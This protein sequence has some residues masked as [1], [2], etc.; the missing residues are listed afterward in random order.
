[1]EV[2]LGGATLPCA[3]PHH[4]QRQLGWLDGMHTC[5]PMLFPL[6]KLICCSP[7]PSSAAALPTLILFKNGRP[8]DRVEGVLM[9]P[10]LKARLEYL[11]A[12]H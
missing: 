12:Q 9:A 11:L 3:A 6:S 5:R 1:M 4:N 8:V 10:D 7:L 2:R